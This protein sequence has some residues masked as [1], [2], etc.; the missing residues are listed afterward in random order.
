[1]LFALTHL[2]LWFASAMH[3]KG[4][5]GI[6]FFWLVMILVWFALAVVFE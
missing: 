2:I 3:D 4:R 6:L 1:M 5:A